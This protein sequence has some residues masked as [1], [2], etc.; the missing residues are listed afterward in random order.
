MYK[1]WRGINTVTYKTWK[2][3]LHS[4]PE[5][6]FG[7]GKEEGNSPRQGIK[8]TFTISLEI[9]SQRDICRLI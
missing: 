6:V 8:L 9:P 5:V 3:S 7:R 4:N 2:E 1:L